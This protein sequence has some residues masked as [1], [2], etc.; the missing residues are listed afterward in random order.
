MNKEF[1]KFGDIE[2]EKQMV[3]Y[4]ESSVKYKLCRYWKNINI[5]Q[6]FLWQKR[7]LNISS[8]TEMKE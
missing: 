4:S 1:L 2:I 6:V 3:Q 5:W 8:A 7:F